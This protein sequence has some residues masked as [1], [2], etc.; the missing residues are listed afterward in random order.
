MRKCEI[1]CLISL[2]DLSLTPNDANKAFFVHVLCH[3]VSSIFRNRKRIQ[4]VFIRCMICYVDPKD[5]DAPDTNDAGRCRSFDGFAWGYWL[6][7]LF[8]MT[9]SA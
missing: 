5:E 1:S 3:G 4:K 9:S 7:T 6:S 8:A 2:N